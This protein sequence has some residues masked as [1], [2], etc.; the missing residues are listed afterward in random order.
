MLPLA[1]VNTP[2]APIGHAG[3]IVSDCVVDVV[4]PAAFVAVMVNV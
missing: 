2:S 3:L 1:I 4:D